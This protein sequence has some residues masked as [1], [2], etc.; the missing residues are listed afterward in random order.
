MTVT[1]AETAIVAPGVKLLAQEDV[2]RGIELT[3]WDV[4]RFVA[5]DTET[6]SITDTVLAP[7]LVCGSVAAFDAEAPGGVG[8]GFLLGRDEAFSTFRE[9]L[10]D[11]HAVLVGAN[12]A[13]DLAVILDEHPE[14]IFDIF[15]LLDQGRVFDVLLAQGLEAI[16]G[17]HLGL[18]HDLSDMRKPSTGKIAKRYSLEVVVQQVLGRADAKANDDYRSGYGDL[19]PIP[20]E[21]WPVMARQYPVDDAVNTL[22]TAVAQAT[23]VGK[24][25]DQPNTGPNRNLQALAGQCR[26][27][28]AEHLASIMGLHVDQA[29]V[30]AYEKEI[31]VQRSAGQKKALAA[32]LLRLKGT[33]K[34]LAAGEG[35]LSKD[36]KEIKRRV[37]V[38][39]GGKLCVCSVG[40]DKFIGCELCDKT[41]V[42]ITEIVKRTDKGAVSIA[43]EVLEECESEELV[44]LAEVSKSDKAADVYIP[45]LR[46]ASP[47]LHPRPNVLLVTLRSSYDGVMQQMPRKGRERACIVSEMGHV[48]GSIDYTGIEAV[49]WSQACTWLV[50]RSTMAEIINA[51]RDI[52]SDFAVELL[53]GSMTYEEVIAQKNVKGSQAAMMR[54]AAKIAIFGFPGGM[55]ALKLVISQ[56][57]QGTIICRYFGRAECV[58]Q[59]VYPKYGPP[60][61]ACVECFDIAK[62]LKR[63]WLQKYPEAPDY[64]NRIQEIIDA[65][66][67]IPTLVPPEIDPRGFVIMRG[68][69]DFSSGCNHLFQSLAACG[70]KQALWEVTKACW[71]GERPELEGFTPR[72]FVHDEF[73][74]SGPEEGAEAAIGAIERIMVEVMRRYCPD[75]ARGV[76]VESKKSKCWV[77]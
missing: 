32:G 18:N 53:G 2:D 15:G 41:G 20:M 59:M 23:G 69:V 16:A 34:Q 58:M 48:L 6:H 3:G 47:T 25:P 28:F 17:G 38:E 52:H 39:A 62:E 24:R 68:G 21:S 26:A 7:R 63:K 11:P 65:T 19:E 45:Y 73:V 14:W 37:L 42:T 61:M 51:G 9:I 77:K 56:R 54:Q 27:A 12:I 30:D 1:V 22:E 5:F 13:F 71:L 40:A 75:V 29:A 72:F 60:V 76:K 64:F 35:E 36:T 8:P 70:A 55:G 33:K 66:G 43:R 10:D 46:S 50:G 49:T 67:E 31:W 44:A 4:R 57:K 74:V